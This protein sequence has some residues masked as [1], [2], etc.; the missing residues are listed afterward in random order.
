[1]ENLTRFRF[2][3]WKLN[4][5]LSRHF[6]TFCAE[7]PVHVIKHFALLQVDR[8]AVFHHADAVDHA[9]CAIGHRKSLLHRHNVA[10]LNKHHAAA[11]HHH[12]SSHG[13]TGEA[14]DF[15]LFDHVLPWLFLCRFRTVGAASASID[16]ECRKDECNEN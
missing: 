13:L 9:P 6:E 12:T 11:F 7:E 16:G 1:M 15:A 3:G 2:V 14:H 10:V 4:T 5:L 8:L